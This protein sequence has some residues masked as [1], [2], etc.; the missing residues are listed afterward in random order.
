MLKHWLSQDTEHLAPGSA[1][2]LFWQIAGDGDQQL[3]PVLES[4]LAAGHGE[5]DF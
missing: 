1:D 5:D 3:A 4:W 2:G